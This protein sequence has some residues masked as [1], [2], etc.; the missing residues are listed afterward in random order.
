MSLNNVIC[1]FISFC[2]KYKKIRVVIWE[3]ME[4]T[5]GRKDVTAEL[6]M[7]I[8]KNNAHNHNPFI[9]PLLIKSH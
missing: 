7:V 9:T 5:K 8:T 4:K 1:F 2:G 3:K 6:F